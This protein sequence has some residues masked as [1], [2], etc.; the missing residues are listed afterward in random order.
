MC[1]SSF[2][3]KSMQSLGC[4]IAKRR[5]ADVRQT[6]IYLQRR[7]AVMRLGSSAEC[8]ETILSPGS[9]LEKLHLLLGW[10][11][12]SAAKPEVQQSRTLNKA[13]ASRNTWFLACHVISGTHRKRTRT[14]RARLCACGL[15][16]P[17]AAAVKSPPWRP[18]NAARPG[19]GGQT[20]RGTGRVLRCLRPRVRAHCIL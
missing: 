3:L 9:Q 13:S 8:R 2:S 5:G 18:G 14:R 7:Q 17:S 15:R 16:L 6:F 11:S 20:R 12:L 10:Y 1:G 4:L 19:S